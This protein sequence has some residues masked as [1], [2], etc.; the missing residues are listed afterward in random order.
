MIPINERVELD[1]WI[2]SEL[3]SLIK[4]VEKSYEDYDPTKATRLIQDFV[5][6][7]L[8]NWH[9]RLSRRRFWKEDYSRHKIAAYQTLFECL[10]V[11]A[12]IASPVAP[13]FMDRLFQ[14]LNIVSNRNSASSV[15]L[16]NFPASNYST[17]DTD[18]ERRMSLAQNATSLVLSLRKR[19]KLRVRQ[20]LQKIMIPILD[21]TTKADINSV[22]EIIKRELNIKDIE[23]LDEDSTVLKKQI[24]PNFKNLGPKFGK[25]MGLIANKIA[26]FSAR[27]IKELEQNNSYKIV[28]GIIIELADVEVSTSDVPGFSVA[29]NNRLTV[30]LDITITEKLREEGL[31]REFVNRI[32][33]LRKD[34]GFEVTD[35]IT[36]WIEKNPLITAAIKNNFI[37]I[38]EETLAEQ[39]NY[40]E[41][42]VKNP[43]EIELV[44]GLSINVSLVKK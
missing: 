40:K 36:I 22:A 5:N 44:N 10:E 16:A 34:S 37:Y 35:K 12:I 38:C 18:L 15:H 2:L 42:V 11:I 31:A 24:K 21:S 33:K 17:I 1:R 32:Q 9:V 43:I 26:Q 7:K 28:D 23:F 30:A 25:K 14:D 29:T 13:F 27:D 4:D 6:D 8:S 39:L 19:K 3:N 41:S 20:P